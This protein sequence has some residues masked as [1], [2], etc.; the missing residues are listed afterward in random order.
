MKSISRDQKAKQIFGKYRFFLDLKNLEAP[1][2]KQLMKDIVY[3][4]GVRKRN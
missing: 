2:V 1:F 4:G 3:V